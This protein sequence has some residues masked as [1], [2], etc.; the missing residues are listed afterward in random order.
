MLS[1]DKSLPIPQPVHG[2]DGTYVINIPEPFTP[3][4]YA[5]VP[6]LLFILP[7][8]ALTPQQL[9]YAGL[10]FDAPGTAIATHNP[11][12]AGWDFDVE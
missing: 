2:T 3:G 10:N 11:T 5:V 6:G 4:H 12:L 9:T 8:I 7:G 1:F